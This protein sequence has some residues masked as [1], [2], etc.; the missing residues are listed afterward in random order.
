M[1]NKPFLEVEFLD[2]DAGDYE[3]EVLFPVRLRTRLNVSS[4]QTS[5]CFRHQ[6]LADPSI[7][8]VVVR[9]SGK[10]KD[11]WQA[12]LPVFVH[13]LRGQVRDFDGRPFPAYPW[14]IEE[15][16]SH[17]QA[18]VQTDPDGNFVFWLP[19]GRRARLFIADESYSETT[20]L[21]ANRPKPPP[22]TR[23]SR[24]AFPDAPAGG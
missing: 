21:F 18:M 19:E 3:V 23:C 15:D 13:R 9:L 4:P 1:Q 6:D 17:P 14:A 11:V 5:V 8:E 24:P 20:K 16:L 10:G 22:N 7:S 12:P 2:L